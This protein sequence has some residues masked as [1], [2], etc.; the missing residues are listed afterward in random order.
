MPQSKLQ[1]D[2]LELFI[3][4]IGEEK[5]KIEVSLLWYFLLII[6]YW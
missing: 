1:I 3:S 5:K 4:N 2:S 6:G